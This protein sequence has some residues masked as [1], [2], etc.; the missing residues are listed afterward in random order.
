MFIA[1]CRH[2]IPGIGC[3]QA[4]QDEKIIPRVKK[5]IKLTKVIVEFGSSTRAYLPLGHL[6]H[7]PPGPSTEKM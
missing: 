6:D 7:A 4:I 1:D 5:E 3:R 2:G